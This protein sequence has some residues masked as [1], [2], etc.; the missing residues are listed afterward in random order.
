MESKMIDKS[1]D[2]VAWALLVS[3][4]EDAAEHIQKLISDMYEIDKYGEPEL[5]VDLGH[6]YSH[7]NRAWHRRNEKGETAENPSEEVW[8]EWSMFPRDL[9][10]FG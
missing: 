8:T 7:L 5:R 1:K 2:Y 6:I 10:L 4:L 9:T 3:E